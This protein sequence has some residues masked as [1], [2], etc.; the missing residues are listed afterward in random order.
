[1]RKLLPMTGFELGPLE[2]ET[3]TLPIGPEPLPTF[4]ILCIN[5]FYRFVGFVDYLNS[6]EEVNVRRNDVNMIKA[7]LRNLLTYSD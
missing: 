1:M 7:L 3:S 6:S 4:V 2:L 5:M